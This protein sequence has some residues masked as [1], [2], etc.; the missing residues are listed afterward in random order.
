[1]AIL[2]TSLDYTDKD[3]TSIRLRLQNLIKSVFPTWTDFNIASFGNLLI[4]MYAFV[5]DIL[6]FYQDN[7]A[8]EGFLQFAKLRRSLLYL[9]KWHGYIPLGASAA[10]ATVTFSI[11][12]I[13]AFNVV[14]SAGTVVETIAVTDPVQFQLLANVTI[15]AGTLSATGTVQN[16]KTYVETF[17]S[18]G[19]AN[20]SY[21]LTNTPFL[22]GSLAVTDVG[23]LSYTVV[24]NFLSSTSANRHVV[25]TVDERDQAT[26]TGGNGTNGT[27]FPAGTLTMTYKVGGGVVGNVEAGAIKRIVGSFADTSGSSVVVSVN[28][29]GAAA[30][31]TDRQSVEQI[32][33]EVPKSLRTLTRAV[34]NED[35]EFGARQVA[36]VARALML[37]SDQE[38]GIAENSGILF[39]IPTGAS[40]ALP[41][42][43]LKEQVLAQFVKVVGYP[44][45][46]YPRTLTF[47]VSVQDPVYLTVNIS[48]I[49]HLK[50]GAVASTVKSAI[51]T[52]LT[53]WFKLTNADG[54]Q[55]TNVDFGFKTKDVNGV[56]DGEVAWSDIHDVLED[57]DGVR[58]VD[59]GPDGLLLNGIRQDVVL[60]NR[61]FPTLGTITLVNGATGLAL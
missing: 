48:A 12:E 57:V 50:E 45:P 52:A 7:Q 35:Y 1:M 15:T 2:P 10:T 34:T 59:A 61:Q 54:T 11:P 53:D 33:E 24:E 36:G 40:G 26:V 32:R 13:R 38:P 28:N 42:A 9:A 3:S 4:E 55:N 58:K 20:E 46:P 56:A 25:V 5:G 8:N 14:I 31:G 16:S 60:G 19:L 22:D 47:N 41:S 17:Q 49:V 23:A 29:T 18:L 30:G 37:T 39:I 6:T 44:T 51:T 27:L 21:V 43:L